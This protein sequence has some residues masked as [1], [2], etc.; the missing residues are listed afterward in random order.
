LPTALRASFKCHFVTPHVP[1][2]PRSFQV[3]TVNDCPVQPIMMQS[4]DISGI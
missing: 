3:K 1:N 2:T 4:I